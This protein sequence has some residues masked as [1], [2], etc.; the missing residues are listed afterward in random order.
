MACDGKIDV[1]S[2]V[3]LAFALFICITNSQ[4]ESLSLHASQRLYFFSELQVVDISYYYFVDNLFE[5][6]EEYGCRGIANM[7]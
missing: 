5:F 2:L 7:D 6:T 4:R 1:I 3:A